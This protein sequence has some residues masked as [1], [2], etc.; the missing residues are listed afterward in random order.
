M[1]PNHREMAVEW[2]K[3]IKGRL[4]AVELS[5]ALKKLPT[6]EVKMTATR[7]VTS[8]QV[9]PYILVERQQVSGSPA[10]AAVLGHTV[11]PLIVSNSVRHCRRV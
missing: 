4:L 6:P 5:K 1:D 3:E 2:A 11:S 9:T 10:T 8:C 7:I